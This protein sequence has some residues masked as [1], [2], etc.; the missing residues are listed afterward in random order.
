MK[1][2]LTGATGQAGWE[3]ARSLM[4]L[5]EV[6]ALDRVACDLAQ[7]AQLDGVVDAIAPD[8]IVNA[9]AYTAVDKAESEPALARTI[10]AESV[11]R[12]AAAARRH[13]A[14]LVHYSTDYV[15]DGRKSTPYLEDDATAPLNVYGESK[16]AGERAI[17]AEGCDHLILRTTWVYAA[18]GHNFVATMLRLFAERER[19]T[20][21]ADQI[22]APTW[23]RNIA[24]TTA[25]L[26][27][28]AQGRR[29]AGEPFGRCFHLTAAGE[30]SWHG[31]AREILRQAKLHWP[32][33]G[34]VVERIDPIPSSAY[35]T[36]AVRPANSRLDGG[37]LA[38]ETGLVLPAWQ[39][40]LARCLAERRAP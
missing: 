2:L 26:V 28:W 24:D 35:P 31:F 7:P 29:A 32:A 19:L 9:A 12:L 34:W 6:T 11:G 30:T 5:G 36:P 8:V 18:R 17:V 27:P 16:L 1:V 13:G 22:G 37:R 15:F 33:H 4:P 21:V 39:D 14:L 20:V 38:R 23:A 25:L 40:A 10:N 3:L